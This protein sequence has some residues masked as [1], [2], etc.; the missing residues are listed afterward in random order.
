MA[1]TTGSALL[2]DILQ[3]LDLR[4]QGVPYVTGDCITPEGT[5]STTWST[6]TN[7][8]RRRLRTSQEPS[9]S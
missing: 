4:P 7:L 1:K 9:Q 6:R 3:G 8:M 5:G 2:T